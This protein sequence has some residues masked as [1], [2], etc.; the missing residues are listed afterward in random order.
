VT[1]GIIAL[2]TACA[3]SRPVIE[4]AISTLK[5]PGIAVAAK[6][7]PAQRTPLAAIAPHKAGVINVLGFAASRR[8]GADTAGQA[9]DRVAGDEA[10]AD[11]C[12]ILQKR[13]PL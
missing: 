10:A 7:S 12:R 5:S 3:W 2:P 13:R 4:V 9:Q 11:S 1:T 6:V 8:L